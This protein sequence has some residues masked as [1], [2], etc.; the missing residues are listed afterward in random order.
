MT[1]CGWCVPAAATR[2]GMR[3]SGWQPASGLGEAGRRTGCC[4]V[5]EARRGKAVQLWSPPR[6]EAGA[7]EA[8]ATGR[9]CV[10]A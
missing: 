8:P 2:G 5:G 3:H 6:G 7:R 9:L 4:F 1:C 10:P